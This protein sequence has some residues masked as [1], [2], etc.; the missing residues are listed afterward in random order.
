MSSSPA[1]DGE[2]ISACIA[3]VFW[4][5]PIVVGIAMF[6]KKGYSPH[7]MW[8]GVHPIGAWIACFVSFCLSHRRRCRNCGG[9]VRSNFRLCPYCGGQD[10][11]LYGVDEIS[12][13]D[14]R[15]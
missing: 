7:W 1:F 8:F 14:D 13:A 5:G 2:I 12:D 10:F 15:M 4:G 6:R 11:P 9:F 3:I